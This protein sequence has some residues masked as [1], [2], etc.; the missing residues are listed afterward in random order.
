MINLCNWGIKANF[1]TAFFNAV[2]YFS[3][4]S[5]TTSMK[6]TLL[7]ALANSRIVS[8]FVEKPSPKWMVYLADLVL[9]A[10]SCALTLAFGNHNDFGTGVLGTQAAR[11]IFEFITYA[12]LAYVLGTS[13]YIIRLSVIEDTYKLV[14][15]A[16]SATCVLG[17]VSL[18]TY[19]TA[20]E[21]YFGFWNIFVIAVM[22][23]T[24]MLLMRLSIKY[25]Y[26]CVA[27]VAQKKR[28][29]IVLGSAINSFFLASALKSE[30][31][32]RF[33]PVALLSL[34][35]R[36]IDS[37]VN[38]IPVVPFDP[39]NV[40][41]T[42]EFF[43]CDTLLFLSTQLE[44]MRSGTADIFLRNNIR[45]LMLNQVEEFDMN[46]KQMPNLS[47][48]VQDIRIED[49]LGRE[50]IRTE[51]PAIR[52]V[53]RNQT[54][55]ITGAAGS[56]GS[57]IVRQV[58][59]LGA[60]DIVLL[61]QA[62]TPMHDMQLEMEEKFPN[63]KIHLFIGDVTNR[64]R[65][66]HAFQKYHPRYVFHAAAYKHVP[67]MERNPPEAVLTNVFGTKN[68]A[69]LSVKYG[70]EKFVMVSTDKAVNPTNVMGASK[71][72]AEIYVQSLFYHMRS[73]S[74]RI[75]TRFITTR[76]G[77][78]LGSNGSVIPL[79]RRQI[80]QGGPVT[81]THRDII[82]YFMT[83]P[84]AC[85]LVL[86]A[87][88][89]GNGGE[90]F[91]FDMGQPVKIWDLAV[92][93]ISLSGLRVNE[94]IEIIETGLRPGEKLYEELLNEKEHTIATHHK[95]IMIAR[96]RTYDFNDVAEHL[97]RLHKAVMAGASHDIVAEMKHIVPEFKSNNSVWQKVDSEIKE[98]HNEA[99]DMHEIDVEAMVAQK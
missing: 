97:E 81:I 8:N 94:D 1:A 63:I 66:E 71:R 44:L 58:A 79:F 24:L 34:A 45:L 25:L 19:F 42:F 39:D 86:E 78:V 51:N 62:E 49:L 41:E 28:R 87:G 88:V 77:N 65:M 82:R 17:L 31:E 99:D 75:G 61:D 26:M 3:D 80:E 33:D 10:F 83:I 4:F 89:M 52:S 95:K 54:V 14:L 2:E 11:A 27:G 73:Q 40:T 35:P 36:N 38:G 74:D 5:I 13:R 60:A 64:D 72:I 12:A 30:F 56:I 9:I 48:H 57:E 15:L 59:S 53:I 93:M 76:F 43:K 16:L 22:S 6:K 46:S 55:M 7:K 50:P 92:R 70:V 90:I 21:F 68:M 91:V 47:T 84:E 85:S 69:D 23:F 32:G 96:V 37:T 29:V 67:M 98:S 18:I 20:G